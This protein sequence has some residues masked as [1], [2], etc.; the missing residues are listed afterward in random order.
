MQLLLNK[1]NNRNF[2]QKIALY[3]LPVNRTVKLNIPPVIL[4]L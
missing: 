1:L 3:L 2:G 4:Q